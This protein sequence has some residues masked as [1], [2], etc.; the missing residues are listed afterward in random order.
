MIIETSEKILKEIYQE[1]TIGK[2]Y[3]KYDF[4]LLLVIGGSEIYSGSP[5]LNAMAAFKAGVDMVRVVAPKKA[6]DIVASFSPNI[7]TYALEGKWLSKKHLSELFFL[8]ESAKIVSRGNLAILIG[9]GMGRSQETK[10]AVQEFFSKNDVPTVIDADAIY[11][12][13]DSPELV[14]DKP[15]IFTP[16]SYEFYILTKENVFP[17]PHQ[18]KQKIVMEQAKKMGT[19]ILLKEK[20][21]IISDGNDIALNYTGSPYMT[22]GGTGDSL[23]GICGAIMSRRISPFLAGQ[24]AAYIN[25]KAGEI[26][27]AKLKDSLTATDVIEAIPQ[28]I[29]Y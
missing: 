20:P 14:K 26:A 25:G 4:G 3:R 17:L 27:A 23:A 15:F 10:E 8:I 6:A 21:D 18:E 16:H 24:A 11:A 9:G 29:S 28:A 19:T 2:Y 13:A 12:I 1:R 22:V 5:A 7:A